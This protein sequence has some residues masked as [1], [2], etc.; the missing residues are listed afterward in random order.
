MPIYKCPTVGDCE[1]ANSGE[2]F[3]RS[4]GEDLKCPECSTL[5]VPRITG[6]KS[7]PDKKIIAAAIAAGIVVIAGA[8]GGGLYYKKSHAAKVEVVAAADPAA[9]SE[10]PAAPASASAPAQATTVGISPSDADINAQRKDGDT[11]LS[12]GD[13]P[14]AESASNQVAAKEM[15]KVA[16]AQMSQGKLDDAEKELNDAATRDPK[17]SLVYYN[18][19]V[20]RLKQGRTDEA[21]KELEASFLNGFSYFDEMQKDPDLDTI[22]N[23]PRFIALVKKYKTTV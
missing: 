15:V 3:V 14:G 8:V 21:F 19:A 6:G 2:I 9:A 10:A 17:Q 1:K 18:M 12:Q 11:K 16:I 7:G 13:A 5:L 4:P 20:L 22:R 23:D